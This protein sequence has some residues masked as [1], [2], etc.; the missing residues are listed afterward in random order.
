MSE[1]EGGRD[2]VRGE[3]GGDGK[4]DSLGGEGRYAHRERKR[5]EGMVHVQERRLREEEK[6]RDGVCRERKRG[7]GCA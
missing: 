1:G 5:R 4:G 7:N 6:G 2:R 3:E